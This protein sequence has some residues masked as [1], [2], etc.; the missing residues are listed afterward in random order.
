M[1]KIKKYNQLL[2]DP[3]DSLVKSNSLGGLLLIFF[4]IVSLFWANSPWKDMYHQIWQT[5]VGIEIGHFK[6]ELHLI[7]WVNDLFMAVFFYLAGLEIKREIVTGELSSLKKA[8]SP[9]LGA[10]GG[11]LFPA[12]IYILIIKMAGV[13]EANEGWGVPMA[14]DI[15]F[16]LGIVSLLGK[17]VPV[18]LKIFLTALAIVDDLGAILVIAIFYSKNIEVVWLASGLGLVVILFILNKLKFRVIPVYHIIGVIIW[19]C[20]FRSGIHATIS[21]VLLAFTIPISRELNVS[22]FK[23]NLSEIQLTEEEVSAHVLSDEQINYI[24]Y[25]EKQISKLQSPIQKLEHALHSSVN[26]FILPLFAFANAGVTISGHS[27]TAISIVSFAIMTGLLLGKTIGIT[28]FSWLGI[29][30]GLTELPA[31]A[32]WKQFIGIAILG[33]L[34]FTM[35]IFIANIAFIDEQLLSQAKIG[36]LLGSFV[37]GIVGYA[38]LKRRLPKHI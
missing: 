19:Y 27:E 14:T 15:A 23:N 18:S 1:G 25:I 11:M 9:A 22:K 31:G 6:F 29:K 10:L 21:G 32:N 12:L 16:S 3:F 5:P 26:Y 20:F 36:I 13:T 24:R 4:T 34:G 30:T 38:V 17:R 8:A 28:F 35:S 2:D 37:S 33:G 7:H